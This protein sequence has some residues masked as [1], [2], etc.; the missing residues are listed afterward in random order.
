ML[1]FTVDRNRDPDGS[2]LQRVLEA[3]INCERMV[4]ARSL[5]AHILAITGL[6]IWL[7]AIWP[8][9]LAPEIRSFAVAVFG[10]NLILALG[11]GIEEFVWRVRLK[12]RLKA[13][14][15]VKLRET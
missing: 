13:N 1:E 3:Q 8:G 14:E 9:L 15:G 5:V 12:R 11:I 4:A 6:V 2:K 7:E 10:G